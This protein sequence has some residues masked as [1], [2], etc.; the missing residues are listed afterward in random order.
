[1]DVGIDSARTDAELL[2]AHAAGISRNE[3]KHRII[4]NAMMP[5]AEAEAFTQLI[6]KRA[7]RIPLQHLT[8]VAPFRYLELQVGPGV[9][10]P[11]PETE[12]VAGA[13]IDR[14]KHLQHQRQQA[15]DPTPI[16]AVDLCTGSGAIAIAIASECPG[17]QVYAVEVDQTAHQWAARN[18]ANL[19]PTIILQHDDALTA[20][21]E[22]NGQVDL[23]IS[24]PPYVPDAER[25]EDPEVSHHDPAL[26]LYDQSDDGLAIPKGII[27]TAARL[28]SPGGFLVMEHAESQAT[29]LVDNL[30]AESQ[31]F[32]HVASHPDLTG[33]NRFVT[34]VR[35]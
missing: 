4:L 2:A 25:P 33:R 14:L 24:N 19:A 28:L 9:F 20:L 13:A 18:I 3:L 22:L 12:V 16:V 31:V 26:A 1:M 35:Y 8:G 5:D 15:S 29:E 30:C 34:A 17:V 23:V 27:K 32:T 7:T 21:P 6:Q 10:I 11:R